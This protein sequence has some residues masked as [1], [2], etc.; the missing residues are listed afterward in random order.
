MNNIPYKSLRHGKYNASLREGGGPRSGGRSPRAQSKMMVCA[1]RTIR[2]WLP[3]CGLPCV[4]GA[5]QIAVGGRIWDPT[6]RRMAKRREQAPALPYSVAFHQSQTTGSQFFNGNFL[7]QK[8]KERTA[9]QIPSDD[10][11]R[12]SIPFFI[13]HSSLF[14]IILPPSGREGDREAVEGARGYKSREQ[15]I[16]AGGYGILFYGDKAYYP[17][18]P[19]HR[20]HHIIVVS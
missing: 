17:H 14:T 7:R 2:T 18:R 3:F 1:A 8:R 13:F 20:K 4:K 15:I 16:V 11:C 19:N 12:N 6:L 10:F 9:E 5:I